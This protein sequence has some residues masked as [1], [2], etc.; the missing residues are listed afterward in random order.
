MFLL[1]QSGNILV[2]V[3]HDNEVSALQ[4]GDFDSAKVVLNESLTTVLETPRGQAVGTTGWQPPEIEGA[5][6]DLWLS[7]AIDG[8]SSTRTPSLTC[9][10]TR[11]PSLT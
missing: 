7:Q 6:P 11:T 5:I 1:F 8:S 10:S 2:S 3:T 4:I 9:P